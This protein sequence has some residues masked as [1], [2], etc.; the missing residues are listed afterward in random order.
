MP[1]PERAQVLFFL[2]HILN[3]NA[4]GPYPLVYVNCPAHWLALSTTYGG[5][6]SLRW[7]QS[8]ELIEPAGKGDPEVS[9][10]L[11]DDRLIDQ[12]PELFS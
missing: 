2:P 4:E 10:M 3:P 7:Y 1:A 8:L 12:R 11:V 6:K 5:G 9:S